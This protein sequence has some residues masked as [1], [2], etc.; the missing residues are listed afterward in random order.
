MPKKRSRKNRK[1]KLVLILVIILLVIIPPSAWFL[2]YG[3]AH[4]PLVDYTFGEASDVR[5]NYTLNAMTQYRPGTIDII[6]VLIR[7]RGITDIS[8]IVTVHAENALLSASYG[9]P[10]REMASNL[11]V[12]LANGKY[13]YVTFYL[14]LRA[15]VSSFTIWCDVTKIADYST[16]SSSVAT[17]FGEIK[18]TSPILLKYK[19]NSSNSAT[20]QLIQS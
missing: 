7:N 9:G 1:R 5:L 17:T 6:N 2:N 13:R 16:M 10:Y 8:V 11:I 14:T 12:S 18:P 19:Q 4:K 20:Y 15:Q 3:L